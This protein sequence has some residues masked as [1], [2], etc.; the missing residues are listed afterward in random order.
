MVNIKREAANRW[1]NK[2]LLW[3]WYCA[4]LA[5][6]RKGKNINTSQRA[7]PF[8]VHQRVW[9]GEVASGPSDPVS[10]DRSQAASD[11]VATPQHAL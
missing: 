9:E 8:E 10:G 11:S 3:P 7:L 5:L 4:S 2:Q 1:L 6:G